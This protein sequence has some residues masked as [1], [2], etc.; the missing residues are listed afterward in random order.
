MWLLYKKAILT[1]DNLAKRRWMGCTKCVSWG[2]EEIIDH[3]FIYCHFFRLVWRVVYFIFNIPPPNNITYL[4]GNWLNGIDK[5]T[6][7]EIRVEVYA[8]VW[9]IKIIVMRF[10]LL[11]TVLRRIVVGA[12]LLRKILVFF[13]FYIVQLVSMVR[14][15][16]HFPPN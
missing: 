10:A 3:L 6:E 1:K 9:T 5:K 2:S 7:E 15:K 11:F 12:N 4:F 16:E 8:L 14:V 13:S